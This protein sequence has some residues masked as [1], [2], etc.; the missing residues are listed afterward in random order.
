MVGQAGPQTPQV[1][2]L[3]NRETCYEL[4]ME[5]PS[6]AQLVYK[7]ALSDTNYYRLYVI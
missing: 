5:I 1:P 2:W 4:N 7:S 6:G 3:F